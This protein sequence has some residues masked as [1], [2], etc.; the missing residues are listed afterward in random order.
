MRQATTPSARTLALYLALLRGINVGG[1]KTIAM[2]DLRACFEAMGFSD[3]QT[4]I[5]SGNVLFSGAGNSTKL[6][7]H[8]ER[9][10]AARFAYDLRVVV[11]THET[12]ARYDVV[13]LKQPLT[14]AAALQAVETRDGVDQVY[15]GQHGLY[16]Q[17][18]IAKATQSRLPRLASK[19]EYQFMT[20]RNWNT[21]TKLLAL[22][23]ALRHQQRWI[24][25]EPAITTRGHVAWITT[26]ARR[27]KEQ[28]DQKPLRRCV[29]LDY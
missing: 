23:D 8:I 9:T 4:Y 13:F 11:I 29:F 6:E 18:L 16:F 22:M 5:Q 25:W 15:T 14:P 12:L 21:T 28:R 26:K 24:R 3:V 7:A 20:I 27:H 19:P 2:A 1:A 17:R 10:L